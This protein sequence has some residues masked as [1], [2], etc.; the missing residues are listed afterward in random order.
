MVVDIGMGGIEVIGLVVALEKVRIREISG[1]CN[2]SLIVKKG[3]NNIDMI[4]FTA[5]M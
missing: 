4:V 3:K 1:T 2:K 5:I